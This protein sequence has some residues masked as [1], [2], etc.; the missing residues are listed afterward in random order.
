MAT[1]HSPWRV[2]GA[3]LFSVGECSYEV[4]LTYP[5]VEELLYSQYGARTLL[6]WERKDGQ[7]HRQVLVRSV[8]PLTPDDPKELVRMRARLME[9]ARLATYLRHP[10]IARIHGCHEVRG[11]LYVVSEHVRGTS[12]NELIN[13]SLERQVR[14]SPAFCMYVGA[15]AASALHAA[16]TCTDER[17]APLGIVHRDVNP[18]RLYLGTGG[19]VVLTDFASAR[20]LLPGRVATTLPRPHG[21]VFYCAPEALLMEQTEPRSDLFALGLVLL[22]LATGRHLYSTARA[23]PEELAGAL[24]PAVKDQVLG[25]VTATGAYPDLPDHV[26]DCILRAATFGTPDL[27]ELTHPLTPP[28]RSILRG[29]LQ[30]RPRERPASAAQARAELQAGLASLEAPYDASQALSEVRR[31]LSGVH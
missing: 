10:G 4:D 13:T 22:E 12:L 25:A 14:L 21:D 15:Q 23:R 17:G 24:T 30:P 28:L 16:H 20:S 26:Q 6:A 5:M 3:M 1:S 29:L 2:P 8:P 27:E 18:A 9:E 11:T 7:L 19:E 31:V